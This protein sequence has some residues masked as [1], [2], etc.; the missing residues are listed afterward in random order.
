MRRA[1]F[2]FLVL[3]AFWMGAAFSALF[4]TPGRLDA[5]D[6]VASCVL[7][8]ALAQITS[9]GAQ[10]T[11]P[12]THSPYPQSSVIERIDWDW[13]TYISAALGSDLWPVTWGSD[14]HLYAAWGDGG[15]FGGSNSDG[16]VALGFARLE[17]MPEKWRG[18]NVNGGKNPDHPASFPKKGK[19]TGIACVDGVIY[20][21]INLEDGAWPNVNHVLAWSTNQGATWTQAHWVFPAGPGNFQPAKFVA[22]GK[23][24]TGLPDSLAGYVYFCGPKQ[25]PDPGS[26][27]Q[28]YLA[29][30]PRTRLR[31]RAAYAFFQQVNAQGAAAWVADIRQAHPVFA[32]PSGVTPGAI[33]YD[34][35]LKRF[36]LTCFHVGPGQLGVFEAANLWGPWSTVAYYQDWGNM[37]SKGEGLTCG[38]PQ[39]WMSDDGLTLWAIFSVYGEGAK[40][41]I[42][43]HD[44]FNLVKAT[45]K[46]FNRNS[47]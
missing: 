19:T 24:Y 11:P 13:N 5:S 37:G 40:R 8:R 36:L 38:F 29:R 14:D 16:R 46:P 23:D 34:P 10:T 42:N 44:R 39:K 17:G 4:A 2:V 7:G 26:G 45:L 32:D 28:L 20:A 27:D 41:G 33:V 6:L 22:F 3:L 31:E 12:Q 15:G 21:T 43:A 18:I 30:A 35:V 25:S 1:A 9:A 47:R